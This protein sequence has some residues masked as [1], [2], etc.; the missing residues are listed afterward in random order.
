MRQMKRQL[1]RAQAEAQVVRDRAAAEHKKLQDIRPERR[2][3]GRF[4]QSP[5]DSEFPELRR[6]KKR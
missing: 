4:N 3:T 2:A 6:R 5:P 1:G